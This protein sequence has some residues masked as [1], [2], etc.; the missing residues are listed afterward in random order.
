MIIHDISQNILTAKVMDGDTEPTVKL[1]QD[2]DSG[3][4]LSDITMCLH[5]GTHIDAPSHYIDNGAT[6]DKVSLGSCIGSCVVVRCQCDI[7]KC[8]VDS[9]PS[10]T[11][12]VLFDGRGLIVTSGAQAIV[13][14]GIRLVGIARRS[15]ANMDNCTSVHQILLGA[16]V[17]ILEGIVLSSIP[18]G[19]YQLIA[20]PLNI[21][22]SE[23]S[24]VRAV[25][26]EQDNEDTTNSTNSR[27][28]P[29]S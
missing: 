14:R 6:I 23:A 1:C 3:Y 2:I 10:G 21:G 18:E 24:P 7:D 27:G 13:D 4:R 5:N 17:V 12:R 19:V 29:D 11:Q 22:N 9:L 25:L 16:G 28:L 8:I 15:V 26:I 20:L